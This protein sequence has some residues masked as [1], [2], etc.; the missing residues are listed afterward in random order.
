EIDDRGALLVRPDRHIAWR[1]STRPESP[2]AVLADALRHALA[3][4]DGPAPSRGV[5]EPVES[6]AGA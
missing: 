6:G 1:A 3:R 5:E 2:R 4:E